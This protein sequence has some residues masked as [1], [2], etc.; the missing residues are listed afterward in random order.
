MPIAIKDVAK[1]INPGEEVLSLRQENALLRERLSA[2][3]REHGHMENIV[4]EVLA[5]V[6]SAA[7]VKVTYKPDSK[8]AGHPCD[9]VMQCSDQHYGAVQ[10]PD[11]V[12][13]FGIYSPEHSR[14]RQ[15]G[16]AQDVLDW[17]AIH[18]YGYQVP[19]LHMV[20]TGDYISGDIHEELRVTNAMPSPVQAV[21]QAEIIGGQVLMMAPH[22]ESVVMHMITDDN[23]GRLTKKPQAKEAGLNNY[24]YIVAQIVKK[25]VANQPNVDCR[26]YAM[27]MQSIDVNGRRYLMMHG[28]GV[29]GWAGFPYYGIERA[30]SREAL[31]RMNAPDTRKFH[32]CILG[33]W[34]APLAHPW[35]WI[36]GS[37]SGTDAFDHKQGRWS[38]PMQVSWVVHPKWGEFNRTEWDLTKWD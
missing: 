38:K 36:G 3:K 21:E 27:P 35:Y 12:E 6:H 18:R 7:P 14:K 1:K 24:G 28:H 32:R 29:Q 30:V 15:F 20:F 16:F 25:M 10:D 17:T 11:E 22:F 13:G 23:H 19:R 5:N 2:Y 34:H 31:K 33:H 9:V 4:G 26:I 8:R 37:V